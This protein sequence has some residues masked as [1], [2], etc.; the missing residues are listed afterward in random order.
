MQLEW[1]ERKRR[2]NL[3]K[4]GIDFAALDP[5]FAGS[6]VEEVD[7][8]RNYGETRIKA[9]GEA[10]GVIV[11]VVYTWRGERR[12]LISARKAKADERKEYQAKLAE[13]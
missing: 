8:R 13:G 7:T 3:A 1:H 2:A 10:N 12:R 6:L 5:M 9:I 11:S 4:H